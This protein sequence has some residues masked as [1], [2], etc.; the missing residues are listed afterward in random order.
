MREIRA[1]RAPRIL[2]YHAI[3]AQA[4]PAAQF[5]WQLR[6]LR[7]NFELVPLP[8]LVER[9]EQRRCTGDEVAITFDDGVRNH[10]TQAAPLLA[11]HGAPATF[12]VCPGLVDSGRWIWNMELRVRLRL[13]DDATRL[14]LAL[15]IRA[16]GAQVEG[17]VARAKQLEPTARQEFEDAVRRATGAFEPDEALLD[18]YAPITWEQLRALDPA[19]FS[20]G[21]HTLTHPILT[22]LGADAREAEIVGSRRRL[23]Q[24][25]DRSVDLF[26]YPNGS[27]DPALVRQASQHYRAAFTTDPGF[28]TPDY[29]L[30]ALPRIPAGPRPGLFLRR[31]HR[32]MA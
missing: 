16:I 21:S 27:H 10:A 25:L 1:I 30:H 3:G 19:L 17:I 23:E 9:I 13:L 18:R 15:S 14:R 4:T 31:L 22:T 11:A 26:C 12:F 5:D 32:P 2:T 20:V 6:M 28:A 7:D 29:P 24:A 8:A